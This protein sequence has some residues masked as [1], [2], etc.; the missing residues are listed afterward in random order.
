VPAAAVPAAVVA[1]GPGTLSAEVLPGGAI[2]LT[3][4]LTVPAHGEMGAVLLQSP[5]KMRR[6]GLAS[7]ASQSTKHR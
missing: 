3:T 2:P 1:V 6:D 5:P 4:V 7:F